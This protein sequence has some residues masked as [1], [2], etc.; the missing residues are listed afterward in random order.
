VKRYAIIIDDFIR[1]LDEARRVAATSTPAD[2]VNPADGKL[3]SRVHVI[4][5]KSPLLMRAGNNF[6]QIMGGKIQTKLSFFRYSLKD[7]HAPYHAHSDAMMDAKYTAVCFLNKAEHCKGGTQ[8]LRHIETG[9]DRWN[10]ATPPDLAA[11]LTADDKNPSKWTEEFFAPMAP[12]RVVIYP[13]DLIH[14]STP[15]NGFGDSEENG[16]LVFVTLFNLVK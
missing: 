11:K 2:T 13:G 1:D 16:R 3:Y 15:W 6:A 14:A 7:A 12:G 9:L 8:F 10:K 4:D 5:A